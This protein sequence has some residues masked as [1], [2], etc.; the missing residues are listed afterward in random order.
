[1]ICFL[2]RHKTSG[3]VLDIGCGDGLLC[4]ELAKRGFDVYGCD[5]SEALVSASRAALAAVMPDAEDRIRL[6]QDNRIPFEMTFDLI[7]I[8][9]VLVYIPNHAAY[10]KDVSA[11]LRPGGMLVASSTQR[12]SVRTLYDVLRN[13]ARPRPV[14]SEWWRGL[15]NLPNTGIW[16]GGYLPGRGSGRTF[17]VRGLERVLRRTGFE[18]VDRLYVY[19]FESLDRRPLE[20]SKTGTAL[21]R[22][23]G[24]RQTVA[25]RLAGGAALAPRESAPHA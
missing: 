23:L 18:P 12:F 25:A 13:L 21:A 8:L 4:L 20:R 6:I 14:R 17:S 9:G 3:S 11:R 2:N 16:S 24:W 10:L 15:M 1:M 19:D 22:T 5:V 7:T